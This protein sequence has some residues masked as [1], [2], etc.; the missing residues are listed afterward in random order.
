[1]KVKVVECKDGNVSVIYPVFKSKR[2]DETEDQWLKRVFDKAMK[3]NENIDELNCKHKT[4]EHTKLP[5]SREHRSAWKFH[6]TKGVTIDTKKIAEIDARRK[7]L[8]ELRAE[9]KAEREAKLQEKIN[10]R[11]GV[12]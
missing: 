9:E 2:E 6:S 7:A 11:L 3:E 10:K 1:M 4:I 8:D 12:K 5:Q